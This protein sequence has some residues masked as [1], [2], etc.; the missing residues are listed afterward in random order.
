MLQFWLN[1]ANKS[2]KVGKNLAIWPQI[3]IHKEFSQPT[4]NYAF[5]AKIDKKKTKLQT[6]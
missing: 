1:S 5:S 2:Q 6:N 3:L 4:P